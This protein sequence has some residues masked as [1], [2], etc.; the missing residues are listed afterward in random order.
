MGSA[1]V[2]EFHE[3]DELDDQSVY[4]FRPSFTFGE[5]VQLINGMNDQVHMCSPFR[6]ILL[7]NGCKT[8]QSNATQ[9]TSEQSKARRPDAAAAMVLVVVVEVTNPHQSSPILTNSFSSRHGTF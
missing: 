2:D 3:L 7:Q 8:T 1:N 4:P 5:D 6:E 9:T